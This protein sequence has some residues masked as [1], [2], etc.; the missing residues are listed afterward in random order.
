MPVLNV[1]CSIV[2]EFRG[3][4]DKDKA[5]KLPTTSW[6]AGSHKYAIII[7]NDAPGQNT[8]GQYILL[9]LPAPH[10]FDR[11]ARPRPSGSTTRFYFSFYDHANVFERQWRPRRRRLWRQK[12]GNICPTTWNEINLPVSRPW[13]PPTRPGGQRGP[14]LYTERKMHKAFDNVWT[15][16]LGKYHQII[17]KFCYFEVFNR[18]AKSQL[19]F[20]SSKKTN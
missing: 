13:G 5:K 16:V 11:K 14:K 10:S 18:N 12:V 2:A 6:R 19:Y 20:F 9:Y 4:A 15:F 17:F 3:R 1:K 7:A 8:Y